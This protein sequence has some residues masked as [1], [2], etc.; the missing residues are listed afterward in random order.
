M[1]SAPQLNL[2]E[3]ERLWKQTLLHKVAGLIDERVYENLDKCGNEQIFRTCKCCGKWEAFDWRCSMKFCPLCNW[4]I[5]R[6]RA[7]LLKI[8]STKITQP[9]HLVLTMK[10]FPVLTRKKIRDFGRAVSKLRRNK[11]WKNVKGGCLSTEITNEGRGW[12]LHGHLLV[13]VRFLDMS[14]MSIAWGALVGQNFGIVKIKDVRGKDY[15][16]EVTKYIVKGSELCAWKP[17]M[18]AQFISAIRGVRFFATFGNLFHMTKEIRKEVF[19]NRP[20]PRSCECGS[21]D[22][23]FQDERSMILRDH[24]KRFG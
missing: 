12:H 22:F 24:K 7:E 9:K 19:L 1:S 6:K 11:I 10:N 4:R 21:D 2:L 8:W 18:I 15:L 20:P 13:D 23:S 3:P 14:A 5:A 17:E 16:G